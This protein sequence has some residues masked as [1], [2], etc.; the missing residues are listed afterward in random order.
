MKFWPT[1][2]TTTTVAVPQPQPLPPLADVH[3]LEVGGTRRGKSVLLELI[4]RSLLSSTAVGLTMID[5]HGSTA[6]AVRDWMANPENGQTGTMLHFLDA[7]SEFSVGLNPLRVN[8]PT[9]W[10]QCHD[11]ASTL[12]SVIES[13]FEASPEETPRLSR[14]V[15]IASMLAARHGLTCLEI[16]EILSLGGHEL[17]RA[18][19]E[20][21][22]NRIVRLEL[23]D[24]HL[25]ATK[26][27]R[28]FLTLV[29]S[30]KNRFVRWLGDRRLAR[31][32]GQTKGLDPRTVMDNGHVFLADLSSLS[33]ADA[34]FVGTIISSM[35][36]AAARKR[37]P[38][39]GLR[40]RLIL[41]EAE[42]MLTAD[43]A[44]GVDQTAKYGLLYTFAIQ[45]LGQLRA[46]GDFLFDALLTNCA[47][48]IC[49][50]GLESE[51]ARYMA[52]N[53][54]AGHIDLEEWKQS[55][56]RPTVV[57]NDK[58]TLRGR[59]IGRHHSEQVAESVTDMRSSSRM[60]GIADASMYGWGSVFTTGSS[61]G[62]AMLPN[63]TLIDAP[64]TLT[65]TFGRNSL[66]GRS[67]TG[68][69]SRV[70]TTAEQQ[71]D[72]HART[73]GR[74]QADGTV[75]IASENEAYN[76]RFA[77]LPQQQFT[78]EEQLAKATWHLM[79]LPRRQCV[80]RLEHN[81][82]YTTRTADL[83]P[84]FRSDA[85][86]DQVLPLYMARVNARS[87]Y[88]RGAAEVD[89]EIAERMAQLTAPAPGEDVDFSQPEP[90]TPTPRKLHVVSKG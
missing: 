88:V 50:G 21:F 49:F 65:N 63:G 68:G 85:F 43:V 84:A 79:T 74:G 13:R 5:P 16:V 19:L 44:R 17:R 67:S 27:P 90:T 70:R 8:D 76:A 11:A 30:C 40:H 53:L 3:M 61:M 12:A 78:L 86:R 80:I 10:E 38:L 66:N 18:L 41:D 4:S 56:V 69:R 1:K 48:K 83:L 23:E 57:G 89:A 47:L 73:A 82:P 77:D 39:K 81:A 54:Y 87:P 26:S 62:S 37:P 58:I 25:L 71:A 35:Y 42:S 36:F 60:R 31:I 28:E 22:D 29:E 34:A 7:G 52:E 9:S 55:T 33:Y 45:R 32:L 59:T 14:I 64:T 24:L 46:R 72:G 20:D 6:R 15:Y 51:S 2:R 75:D